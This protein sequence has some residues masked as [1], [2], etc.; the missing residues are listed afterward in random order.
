MFG[1]HTALYSGVFRWFLGVYYVHPAL[2]VS[3]IVSGVMLKMSSEQLETTLL[4]KEIERISD[5]F[6][7]ITS[8]LYDNYKFTCEAV[9]KCFLDK[10]TD[11]VCAQIQRL[12]DAYGKDNEG[13]WQKFFDERDLTLDNYY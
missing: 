10:D 8:N 5:Y 2:L 11:K 12:I 4:L 1:L 9:D 13:S 6:S 3:T 7:V